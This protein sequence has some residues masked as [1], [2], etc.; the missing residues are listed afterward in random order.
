MAGEA[1]VLGLPKLYEPT[2]TVDAAQNVTF[3]ARLSEPRSWTVTVTNET[4]GSVASRAGNGSTIDWTWAADGIPRDVYR[5]AIEAGAD[6]RPATGRLP[7]GE[8]PGTVEPPAAP[9]P[10]RRRTAPYSGLGL[11]AAPLAA[12]AEGGAGT[13]AGLSAAPPAVVVLAVV[14]LAERAEA[15]GRAVRRQLARSLA[16]LHLKPP[17]V[18]GASS[19]TGKVA[20]RSYRSTVL[21][22]R[23]SGT[24]SRRRAGR[25]RGR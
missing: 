23:T 15:L 16:T 20:S 10:A 12:H 1:A 18:V 21:R 14:P 13:A 11:G 3:Q 5:Y 17:T 9:T 8:D 4:G 19:R 2:V 6:V 7:L 24:R 25:R 22:G